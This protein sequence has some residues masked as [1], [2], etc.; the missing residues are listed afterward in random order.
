MNKVVCF[1][2]HRPSNMPF[3]F[4]NTSEEFQEL[5]ERLA[6]NIISLIEKGYDTFVSGMAL[7]VD[8]LCAEIV[9]KL[10]TIYPINLKC[11]LPCKNQNQLW[12]K[13][14][15]M[16]YNFI[17]KSAN[18]IVCA[19]DGN[20][21]TGCMHLRNKMMVDDSDLVLAVYYGGNGGTKHTIDYANSLGKEILIIN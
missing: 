7:G 17:L 4:N 9:I 19:V 8:M 6:N 11:Y 2:G 21:T 5:T 15:K 14:D 13:Y 18:E 20:Y 12:N 16:K 1:T 10:K 3:P